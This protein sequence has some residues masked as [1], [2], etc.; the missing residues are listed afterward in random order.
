MKSHTRATMSLGKGP[1]HLCSNAQKINTKS[2]TE[3][4][5]VAADDVIPM[6]LSTMYFLMA[7]GYKVKDNVVYQDKKIT[8]LLAKNGRVSSGKEQNI[9]TSDIT[10]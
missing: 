10:L 2:S 9:S 6:V 3:S 1:I 5:L 4:A 7:Q 8:M